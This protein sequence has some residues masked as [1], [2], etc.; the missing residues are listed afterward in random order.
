MG[1]II[2]PIGRFPLKLIVL[3]SNAVFGWQSS[4]SQPIIFVTTVDLCWIG[5][6]PIAISVTGFQL[7]I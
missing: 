3:V 1:T 4:M 7:Q 5:L 6:D 2:D